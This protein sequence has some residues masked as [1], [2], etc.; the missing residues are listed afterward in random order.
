[1]KPLKILDY[2]LSLVAF[3]VVLVAALAVASPLSLVVTLAV[4]P[5]VALW[6]PP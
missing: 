4:A 1:L 6:L 5:L 2:S 3:A